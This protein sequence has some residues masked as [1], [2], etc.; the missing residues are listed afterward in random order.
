MCVARDIPLIDQIVARLGYE[1]YHVKRRLMGRTS[2]GSLAFAR[3]GLERSCVA[4]Y[5]NKS[6]CAGY[7][8]AGDRTRLELLPAVITGCRDV[9]AWARSAGNHGSIFVP[10]SA[11]VGA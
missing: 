10:A 11:T 6:G 8:A 9:M 4:A 1:R 7:V 3:T 2:L 5:A